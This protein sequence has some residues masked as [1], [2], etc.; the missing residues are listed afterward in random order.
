LVGKRAGG[1]GHGDAL[2]FNRFGE[3]AIEP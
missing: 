1:N 3:M 2:P